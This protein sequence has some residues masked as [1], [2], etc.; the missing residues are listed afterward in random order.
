MDRAQSPVARSG[1][2]ALE[3]GRDEVVEEDRRR[4]RDDRPPEDRI[5]RDR[6]EP[7]DGLDALVGVFAGAG[8][9]RDGRAGYRERGCRVRVVPGERGELTGRERRD[10]ADAAA[11]QSRGVEESEA[12]DVG[13]GVQA[14]PARRAHRADD[15]MALLPHAEQVGAQTGATRDDTNGV[16]VDARRGPTT[17]HCTANIRGGLSFVHDLFGTEC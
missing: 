15:A 3:E 4:Q 11:G 5:E 16:A 8:I 7:F 1:A 17:S 14:T 2:D 10:R 13:V 9:G 6:V 12:L